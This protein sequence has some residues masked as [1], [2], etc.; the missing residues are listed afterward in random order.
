MGGGSWGCGVR[1]NGVNVNLRHRTKKKNESHFDLLERGSTSPLE[2]LAAGSGAFSA[3]FGSCVQVQGSGVIEGSVIGGS[4]F[5]ND[6][7]VIEGSEVSMR[8]ES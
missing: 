8:G 5:I 7:E 6:S 3:G 1:R 4:G 2:P